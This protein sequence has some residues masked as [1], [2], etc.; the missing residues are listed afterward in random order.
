M[1]L[2]L[3]YGEPSPLGEHLASSRES[4]AQADPLGAEWISTMLPLQIDFEVR[5]DPL[6]SG[7]FYV[8]FE[9]DLSWTQ[10]SQ[11]FRNIQCQGE[12]P[13]NLYAGAEAHIL[14][15]NAGDNLISGGLGEDIFIVSGAR[16]EYDLETTSNGILLFDSIQGRDGADL[17]EEIEIIRFTD[18][19]YIVSQ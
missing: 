1:L 2:S 9:A 19:D 7:S 16:S 11:Y 5:I 12:L 14:K 10:R 3:F 6:F 17:L 18:G 4:L 15:G 8:R 13:V